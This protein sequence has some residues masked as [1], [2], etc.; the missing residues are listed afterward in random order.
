MSTFYNID[1]FISLIL[2]LLDKGVILVVFM[3]K[4]YDMNS[5]KILL[6]QV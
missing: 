2:F 6:K 1:Y 5:E 4:Y 3:S